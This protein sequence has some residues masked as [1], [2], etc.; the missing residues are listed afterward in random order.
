MSAPVPLIESYCFQSDFY[1]NYDILTLNNREVKDV[2]KIGARMRKEQ[3]HKC[4]KIINKEQDLRILGYNLDNFLGLDDKD[5]DDCIKE[6][7]ERVIK[8]LLNIEGVKLSKATKVLHTL[9]PKVIPILDDPLQIEYSKEINTQWDKKHS[10]QIFNDYYNNLRE[11]QN[12]HNLTQIS[13]TLLENN[14]CGLTKVR[15]FDII[16]WSYLKSR[17]LTKELKKKR[18]IAIEWSTVRSLDKR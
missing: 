7:D 16:W 17:R 3:L 1:R 5:R 2:N 13:N 15:I 12:L 10:T 9:Y 18:G 8:R 11:G 4:E 6:L 14:L